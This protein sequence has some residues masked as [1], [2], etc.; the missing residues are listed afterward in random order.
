M[1]GELVENVIHSQ[2][3]NMSREIKFRA[4]DKKEK[5]MMVVPR[6]NFGDDGTGKTIIL[7]YKSEDG[8]DIGL[9]AGENC[10]LMQFT[11]LLDKNGKEIYD[12]DIIHLVSSFGA[13]RGNHEVSLEVYTADRGED[14]GYWWYSFLP[15]YVEIIGNIYQNPELLTPSTTE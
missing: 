12:G 2:P 1:D 7:E 13:D 11:G 4:W 9:V 5:R 14:Y 8:F 6:I 3:K 10:G 15:N